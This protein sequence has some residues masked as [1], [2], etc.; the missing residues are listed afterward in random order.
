MLIVPL[1]LMLNATR[2]VAVTAML[3]GLSTVRR[4]TVTPVAMV[5][6]VVAALPSLAATTALV[7]M[8]PRVESKSLEFALVSTLITLNDASPPMVSFS[9]LALSALPTMVL[10]P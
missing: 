6:N 7:L 4:L 2:S 9:L 5:Y 3:F 1:S 8:P 10:P